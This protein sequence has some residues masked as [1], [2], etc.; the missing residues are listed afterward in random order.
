[1]DINN[2]KRQIEENIRNRDVPQADINR[3]VRQHILT[4]ARNFKDAVAL[5][6]QERRPANTEQDVVGAENVRICK[7][8]FNT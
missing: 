3:V 5:G 7:K 8:H 1:L 6:M 4:P 2:L